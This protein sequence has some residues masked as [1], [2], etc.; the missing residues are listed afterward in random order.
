METKTEVLATVPYKNA[1][2]SFM[3]DNFPVGIQ[4]ICDG[5]R[6]EIKIERV[7]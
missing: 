4:A 5:D 1:L 3:A 6:K 7:I 2:T